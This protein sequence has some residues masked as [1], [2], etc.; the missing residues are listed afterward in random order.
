MRL[1]LEVLAAQLA[2]TRIDAAGAATLRQLVADAAGAAT[3]TELAALNSAFH[4]EI[5]R[6]SGNTSARGHHGLAA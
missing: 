6:L 5:C 1:A 2:A 3:A 4:G